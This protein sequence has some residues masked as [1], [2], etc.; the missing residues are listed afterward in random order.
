MACT[1][2][3]TNSIP[4]QAEFTVY[5]TIDRLQTSITLQDGCFGTATLMRIAA[6]FMP[7]PSPTPLPTPEQ[8]PPADLAASPSMGPPQAN[9]ASTANGE[10][11]SGKAEASAAT[12]V[13]GEHSPPAATGADESSQLADAES[14]AGSIAEQ[15]HEASSAQGCIPDASLPSASS[16]SDS[17]SDQPADQPSDAFKVRPQTGPPTAVPAHNRDSLQP[18]FEHGKEGDASLQNPV[19]TMAPLLAMQPDQGLLNAIQTPLCSPGQGQEAEEQAQARADSLL[20]TQSATDASPA[21]DNSVVDL[22]PDLDAL[23]PAAQLD[24]PQSELHSEPQTPTASDFKEEVTVKPKCKEQF[25]LEI[26]RCK[27]VCPARVDAAGFTYA[28]AVPL[29]HM[30]YMEIPHFLLQLPL[31][32]PAQHPRPHPVDLRVRHVLQGQ[33]P[34]VPP[35]DVTAP[36]P[37]AS[38]GQQGTIFSLASLTLFVAAPEEFESARSASSGSGGQ[39]PPFLSIPTASMTALPQRAPAQHSALESQISDEPVPTFELELRKAEVIAR[40]AQLQTVS[41]STIRYS[42]DMDA[43]LGKPPSAS[44]AP[45]LAATADPSL[46]P[47]SDLASAKPNPAGSQQQP[48]HQPGFAV[49]AS[50]GLISLQLHSS[51]KALPALVL[52]WQRLA[53]HYTQAAG[54]ATLQ[55]VAC[56]IVWHF[57]ALQLTENPAKPQQQFSLE[58]VGTLR[59][60][61][62]ALPGRM[63]RVH[64]EPLGGRG[65]PS[66][67]R[68][69]QHGSGRLTR[70]SGHSSSRR[71]LP[72][73]RTFS[74]EEGLRHQQSM[75]RLQGFSVGNGRSGLGLAEIA[76]GDDDASSPSSP[77]YIFNN[78]AR[79]A[80]G[81]FN[82]AVDG[83]LTSLSALSL[84]KASQQQQGGSDEASSTVS[85]SYSRSH[86]H[87]DLDRLNFPT[88]G[89][90]VASSSLSIEKLQRQVPVIRH[91]SVMMAFAPSIPLGEAADLPSFT[92]ASSSSLNPIHASSS[93]SLRQA[94]SVFHDAPESLGSLRRVSEGGEPLSP[95][96]SDL[97][98][99][100]WSANQLP[101]GDRI[102]LLLGSK[103]CFAAKEG[104]AGPSSDASIGCSLMPTGLQTHSGAS[105]LSAL[106]ICASDML[107]RVYLEVRSATFC[108]QCA[109]VLLCWTLSSAQ[110]PRDVHAM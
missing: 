3:L 54:P 1:C 70:G 25:S 42:T 56:G 6:L 83:I 35:P 13:G 107:L 58:H 51:N 86:R 59:S 73:D 67:G 89:T 30:L 14:S 17:K 45:V 49:E 92:S 31:S 26:V 57:L 24:Q 68:S 21:S 44:L 20:A 61:S 38:T 62:L 40:P 64:S 75:S 93:L 12:S 39:L 65:P 69:S 98:P 82:E 48:A 66:T 37:F 105:A 53:G 79:L 50:V 52:Q 9:R 43:I 95:R 22:V 81:D 109:S 33:Q 11:E 60:G 78:R 8:Q 4:A 101:P 32:Q 104:T 10:A 18:T 77:Q 28:D 71:Q 55:Q 103:S 85:D 110:L 47:P 96:G 88:R 106:E 34:V 94:L 99:K 36:S 41:A 91:R 16:A 87:R 97:F 63:S 74:P 2:R 90:S 29:D 72:L 108:S 19:Q 46:A 102:L 23:D 7:G 15:A 76:A 84:N 27:I 80:S 5:D 100:D